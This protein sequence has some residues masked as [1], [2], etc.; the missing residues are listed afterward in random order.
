MVHLIHF[1]TLDFKERKLEM[2]EKVK[3]KVI[4]IGFAFI[5]FIVLIS[6]VIKKDEEISISERR[7]LARYRQIYSG[8]IY[9]KR[10]F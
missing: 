8:P 5:L 3:N 7:K 9:F 1:C 10:Y 6:N 2:K 4:A